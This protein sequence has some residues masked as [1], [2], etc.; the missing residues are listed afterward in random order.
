MFEDWVMKWAISVVVGYVELVVEQHGR[1][2]DIV[3]AYSHNGTLQVV[4]VVAVVVGFVAAVDAAV[5]FAAAGTVEVEVDDTPAPAP[6]LEPAL[7]LA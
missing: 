1:E 7:A 3:S 2:L 5:A 6:V 4:V